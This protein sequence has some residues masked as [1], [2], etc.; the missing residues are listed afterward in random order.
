MSTGLRPRY[1]EVHLH[2]VLCGHLCEVG[3]TCRFVPAE[4]FRGDPL[5]PTLSL[6]LTFPGNDTLSASVLSNPDRKSVV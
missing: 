4:A 1:L 3:R 6:S 2:G 5:R